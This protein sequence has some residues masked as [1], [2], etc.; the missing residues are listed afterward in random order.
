MLKNAISA[1][2]L[3]LSLSAAS[4]APLLFDG[5]LVS[6]GA[7]QDLTAGLSSETGSTQVTF[8]QA[9]AFAH[10]F[11]F[12][13]EGTGQLNGSLDHSAAVGSWARQGIEFDEIYFRDSANQRIFGSDFEIFVDDV[14]TTKFTFA[15]SDVVWVTGDFYLY[16]SGFAGLGEGEG[17]YSY[18][19]V[20]NLTPKTDVPEPASLVLVLAA[21]GAAAW[22]R[23]RNASRAV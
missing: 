12:K 22:V 10:L 23:R 7:G 16:V 2:L 5:T 4:A 17:A 21:L 6:N 1:A 8:V 3:A 11:K 15:A 18:S 9:G 20:L 19:G 13:F 14:G